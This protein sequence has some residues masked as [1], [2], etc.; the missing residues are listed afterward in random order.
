MKRR[1]M[2]PEKCAPWVYAHAM[3]HLWNSSGTA[4]ISDLTI[5]AIMPKGAGQN[6]LSKGIPFRLRGWVQL[7]GQFVNAKYTEIDLHI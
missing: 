6:T 1:C 2:N 4:S 7:L 3:S 5:K